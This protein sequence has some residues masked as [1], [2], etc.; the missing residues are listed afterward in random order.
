MVLRDRPRQLIVILVFELTS[1]AL[2]LLEN[3]WDLRTM[4]QGY[5]LR[6]SFLFEAAGKAVRFVFFFIPSQIG[7]FEGGLAWVAGVMGLAATVGFT[8]ALVRRLRQIIVAA[9][10]LGYAWTRLRS[11]GE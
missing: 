7:A 6:N 3:Y 11:S 5:S 2:L 10:G 1:Q 8:L 9:A 4:G